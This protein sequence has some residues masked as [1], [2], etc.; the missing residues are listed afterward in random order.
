MITRFAIPVENN[1]LSAHFGHAKQFVFIDVIDGKITDEKYFDP[2]PHEPGRIPIRISQWAPQQ[3]SQVVW[4][5]M[6]ELY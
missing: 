1:L 3:F 6:K 5:K 4:V 2:P